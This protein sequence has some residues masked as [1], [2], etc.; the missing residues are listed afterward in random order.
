VDIRVARLI[1]FGIAFDLPHEALIMAACLSLT[2]T[3]VFSRPFQKD[4]E[5][6]PADGTQAARD[7]L[8][9]APVFQDEAELGP[10]LVQR[11]HRRA[12]R[13]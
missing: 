6:T 2:G 13:V 5:V 8:T 7:P 11:R 3:G 1:V 9:L 12:A 10:E 4:F